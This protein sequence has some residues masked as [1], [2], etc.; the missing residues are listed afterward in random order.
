MIFG[1]INEA[2]MLKYWWDGG[3]NTLNEQSWVFAVSFLLSVHDVL[4]IGKL[5]AR[6]DSALGTDPSHHPTIWQHLS[7]NHSLFQIQNFDDLSGELFR[8]SHRASRF[9][10]PFIEFGFFR[11]FVVINRLSRNSL[12][13]TSGARHLCQEENLSR[14]WPQ[15]ITRHLAPQKVSDLKEKDYTCRLGYT[16]NAVTM[17]QNV[18]KGFCSLVRYFQLDTYAARSTERCP[19]LK[20]YYDWPTP[21]FLL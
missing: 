10:S 6:S 17:T 12:P 14:C 7:L 11:L 15:Q 1:F 4:L 21:H 9:L 5:S 3:W 8:G 20:H 2:N 18:S 19:L 16:R 13:Q